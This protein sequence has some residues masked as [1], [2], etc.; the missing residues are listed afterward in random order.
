[1]NYDFW[2]ST[3]EL[4]LLLL[5]LV[6]YHLNVFSWVFVIFG[7]C[8]HKLNTIQL[9]AIRWCLFKYCTRFEHGQRWCEWRIF[10]L[11]PVL[12]FRIKC[13]TLVRS[14]S[15]LSSLLILAFVSC[16]F[17]CWSLQSNWVVPCFSVLTHPDCGRQYL[18][19][20]SVAGGSGREAAIKSKA[21]IKRRSEE[22]V[23]NI[24]YFLNVAFSNGWALATLL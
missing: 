18:Y 19:L 13:P 1:M 21:L 23:L 20:L 8:H 14:C 17:V 11:P 12:H 22:P 16:L 2:H 10:N 15:F 6:L 7:V 4:W 9:I 3:R 5:L 24:I